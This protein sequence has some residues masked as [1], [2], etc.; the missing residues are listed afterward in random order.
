MRT[1]TA[2]LLALLT[3]VAAF[4][5]SK[6]DIAAYK[7]RGAADA[8][9]ACAAHAGTFTKT[10]GPVKTFSFDD[11]QLTGGKVED[12]KAPFKAGDTA[13]VDQLVTLKSTATM[14]AGGPERTYEVKC[15]VNGTKVRGFSFRDLAVPIKTK[16]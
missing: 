3:P 10:P 9:A 4:A 8:V 7:A 1:S 2:L 5:Q 14:R 15:G 16:S 13:V 6:G 12:W 11:A